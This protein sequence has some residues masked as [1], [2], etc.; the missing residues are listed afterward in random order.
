VYN[1]HIQLLQTQINTQTHTKALKK[2]E[3]IEIKMQENS[4]IYPVHVMKMYRGDG[5]T[6]LIL[7]L[8]TSSF[9]PTKRKPSIN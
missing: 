5:V 7:N 4:K 6:P 2:L 8:G 3:E 9:I 1:K